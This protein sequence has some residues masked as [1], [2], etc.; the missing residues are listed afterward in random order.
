MLVNALMM[1]IVPRPL[2]AAGVLVALGRAL[3]NRRL[4]AA[5]VG[6]GVSVIVFYIIAFVAL[7]LTF[8]VLAEYGGG[9]GGGGDGGP[10][11]PA[12]PESL[13]L[14][15]GIP[16]AIVGAVAAYIGSRL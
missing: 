12:A 16:T 13:I 11:D 10:F 4:A 6:A 5:G 8:A 9:G 14:E 2:I 7:F 1:P 15:V 3:P